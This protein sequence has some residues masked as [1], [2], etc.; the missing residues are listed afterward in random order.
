MGFLMILGWDTNLIS[1]FCDKDMPSKFL[2]LKQL[3]Y[4]DRPLQSQSRMQDSHSGMDTRI[5]S[6]VSSAKWD[7]E[8]GELVHFWQ[9]QDTIQHVMYLAY[10]FDAFFG[11]AGIVSVWTTCCWCG[12]CWW[13]CASPIFRCPG[14]FCCWFLFLDYVFAVSLC[15][16]P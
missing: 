9:F 15:M 4:V 13:I 14:C 2:Y 6:Q 12:R 5:A 3:D 11:D 16:N 1:F 8:M 7:S 10:G